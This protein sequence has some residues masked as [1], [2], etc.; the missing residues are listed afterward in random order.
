IELL[1]PAIRQEVWDAIEY[2]ERSIIPEEVA[3]HVD[4]TLRTF[5]E[6]DALYAKGRTIINPDGASPVKP[7]GNIVTRA[8]G[9]ESFHNYGLA[10]DFNWYW[11]K[12]GVYIYDE[13]RSWS[14][15][16]VHR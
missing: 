14:I 2:L 5:I 10:L 8:K 16:P 1:H 12:N 15:G 13:N 7:M 6:Q 4:S 3:F 9:G 11:K